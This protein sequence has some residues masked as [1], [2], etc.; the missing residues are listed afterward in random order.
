MKVNKYWAKSIMFM[1]LSLEMKYQIFTGGKT[2]TNPKCQM[3]AF[4]SIKKKKRKEKKKMD[5]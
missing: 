2:T 5:L 1:C 3:N 4:C